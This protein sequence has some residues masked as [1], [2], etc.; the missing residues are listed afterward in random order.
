MKINT[1]LF[2]TNFFVEH[3]FFIAREEKVELL[4]D[5]AKRYPKNPLGVGVKKL[6][7]EERSRKS[8]QRNH[9]LE[10]LG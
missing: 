9:A 4:E 7:F 10:E 6:T 2:F 1:F 8:S 5:K 3:Y